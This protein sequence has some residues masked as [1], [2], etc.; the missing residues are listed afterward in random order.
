[1]D[2]SKDFFAGLKVKRKNMDNNETENDNESMGLERVSLS[3]EA[4]AEERDSDPGVVSA[5]YM[6]RTHG[7]SHIQ[8]RP[9]QEDI[10]S[11]DV[12]ANHDN[13]VNIGSEHST[14]DLFVSIIRDNPI[15]LDRSQVPMVKEQKSKALQVAK[16][17]IAG[18][19][20]KTMNDKQILK[21]IAN[22]KTQVRIRFKLSL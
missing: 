1:M 16:V 6:D 2:D 13:N 22:M 5:K 21:R 11:V 18:N 9:V 10:G 4:G 8:S 17:T 12:G 19:L 3:S 14:N 15:L 20:G 7:S